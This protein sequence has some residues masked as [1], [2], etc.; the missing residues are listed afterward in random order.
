MTGSRAWALGA[1]MG[2]VL[3]A[4]V[5][6]AAAET[7]YK[8]G[9]AVNF[10]FETTDDQLITSGMLKG[11]LVVVHFWA[12]I[13]E[14]SLEN[15]PDIQRLHE[16]YHKQGVG[17]VSVSVDPDAEAARQMAETQG[18]ET[19]VVINAEQTIPVNAQFFSKRYGVPHAFIIS[20][21]GKLIWDGHGFLLEE[22]LKQAMIDFPPP[23]D[24][25]LGEDLVV[26]FD[27][28]ASSVDAEELAKTASQAMFARPMDFHLLFDAVKQLPAESFDEAKVKA[29]GRAVKRTLSNLDP[30]QKE[31][32]ELYR[33]TYPTTAQNLDDWLAASA[34]S[35]S[36]GGGGSVSPEVVA[37][38]F[39]QA[40]DA[41][42]DGDDLAA[43]ELYRWIVDRA[44][45]SDEAL[46]AQDMVLIMEGDEALMGQVQAAKLEGKAQNLMT[47]AKNYANAGLYDKAEET[48][49]KVIDQYPGTDAAKQA[50]E[51]LK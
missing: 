8:V 32:Y 13:S 27:P 42:A 18:L 29:F 30:E 11:Y 6:P 33:T 10:T 2:F 38:K 28:F 40:E 23:T 43:Y 14:P 47:M 37:S 3:A 51:E 12:A 22:H 34:R 31:N 5:Q 19:L 4:V 25:I 48:Y 46:L 26:D 1:M 45:D 15:L 49:Q 24:S 7:R 21:E 41:E 16:T 36:S 39:Q 20:P 50:S 9:D 44:P 35:I 17:I